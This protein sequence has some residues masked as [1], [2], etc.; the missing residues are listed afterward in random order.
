VSKKQFGHC[1]VHLSTCVYE[2]KPFFSSSSRVTACGA[3]SKRREW[4]KISDAGGGAPESI[5]ARERKKKLA[6]QIHG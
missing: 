1:L 3:K 4:K 6:T 5:R 2:W